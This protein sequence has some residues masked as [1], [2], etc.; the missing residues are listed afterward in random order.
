LISAYARQGTAELIA[1]AGRMVEEAREAEKRIERE[2]LP[3]DEAA[4]DH[5]KRTYTIEQ[6]N[7]VYYV[8]GD[9]A[10]R[11]V[12][13]TDLKDPESLFHLWQRLRVMGIIEELLQEGVEPGSEVS[14]GGVIFTYGEGM[15]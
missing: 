8:L 2:A 7:G 4:K 1:V 3:V 12:H 10:T 13:V 9:R 11:L 6:R 15:G 14:I 5:G